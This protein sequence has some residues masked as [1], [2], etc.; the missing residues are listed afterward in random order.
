LIL[1]LIYYSRHVHASPLR[2]RSV[3]THDRL[4]A[5][6]C[7]SFSTLS[8]TTGGMFTRTCVRVGAIANTA[9]TVT[10]RRHRNAPRTLPRAQLELKYWERW[11]F[12]N[13]TVFR[14]NY[15]S[16]CRSKKKKKKNKYATFELRGA[17]NLIAPVDVTR[18]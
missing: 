14:C 13:L 10:A 12:P 6:M 15:Y 5:V 7:R 4:F 8:L 3:F 17:K 18:H 2:A 9:E 1:L 16:L 11:N